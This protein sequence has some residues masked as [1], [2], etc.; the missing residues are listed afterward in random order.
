MGEILLMGLVLV[1]VY[2]LA[3]W[4]TLAV[5]RYVDRPLGGWRTAVFF[6]VFLVMLLVAIQIVSRLPGVS[7]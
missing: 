2:L 7:G 3:H 5:E 6:V 1:V 4:L